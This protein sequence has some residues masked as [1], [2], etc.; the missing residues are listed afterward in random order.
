MQSYFT[1]YSKGFVMMLRQMINVQDMHRKEPTYNCQCFV[2]L[3]GNKQ[4]VSVE[5][6][7]PRMQLP[8]FC[9]GVK[10]NGVCVIHVI[11]KASHVIVKIKRWC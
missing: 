1:C 2:V 7:E 4:Y 6:G 5:Y 10:T 3:L 8:K 9:A 11:L